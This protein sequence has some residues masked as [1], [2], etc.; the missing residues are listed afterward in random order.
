MEKQR[1][2]AREASHTGIGLH[3]GNRSTICFK[4]ADVNSGVKFVRVDLPGCPEIKA[5]IEMV[6]AAPRRTTL[7]KGAVQIHTVEHILAAL[8]GLGIDNLTIEVDANEVPEIDGSALP[9]VQLLKEAGILEQD[10]CKNYFQLTQPVW[11]SNGEAH[12]TAFPSDEMRVSFTIDYPTSALGVQYISNQIN[13][14]F[15]AE[16]IAAA[17]TFCLEQEAETL[18]ENGLGKGATLENTVVVGGKGVVN[19][20]LRFENEFVRHKVLD[21]MGDLFLLGR[22]LKAHLVAAKSGHGQNIE[23]VRALKAMVGETSFASVPDGQGGKEKVN[24]ILDTVAIK[25]ILPHRYPFLFVDKIIEME[26]DKRIVGIKNVTINDQFF[27]GHFPERPVMP[28]VLIIE[29]M[30]QTAGVLMLK[31][32]ENMGKLAYLMSIDKVKLRRPIVPG[33]QLRLEVEVSKLRKRAGK[34]KTWALVEG[35]LVA[36]AELVFSLVEV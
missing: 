35:Q 25:N 4:P 33:D 22:P 5:T 34:V 11:I 15:F 16:Q 24:V 26:E 29:A 32:K 20:S 27:V 36:E 14:Q 31:K 19:G 12:L 7:S 3:T 9:F 6:I 2:V 23:L 21:L 10:A 1:T 17:R 13:E 30:A 18:R 28:G 8:A